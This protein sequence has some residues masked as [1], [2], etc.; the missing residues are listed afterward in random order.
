MNGYG[1]SKHGSL[2]ATIGY[3]VARSPAGLSARELA[4]KLQHPCHAVLSILHKGQA[5]DRVKVASHTGEKPARSFEDYAPLI[6][7]DKRDLPE[8]VEIIEA[9]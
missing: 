8:G 3:L 9:F 1:F 2:T 7:I 5:L 6:S 4:E